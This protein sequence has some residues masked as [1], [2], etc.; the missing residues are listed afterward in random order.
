MAS[1]SRGEQQ[2]KQFE[3]AVSLPGKPRAL[4]AGLDCRP[5]GARTSRLYV[6]LDISLAEPRDCPPRNDPARIA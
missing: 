2:R 4:A 3:T 1:G 6:A 5:Y